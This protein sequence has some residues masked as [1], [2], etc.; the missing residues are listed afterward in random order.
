MTMPMVA[1]ELFP[2]EKTKIITK[3]KGKTL[4]ATLKTADGEPIANKTI[5]F[6]VRGKNFYKKTNS[7]GTATLKFSSYSKMSNYKW[8]FKTTFNGDAKYKAV[9]KQGIIPKPK[10]TRTGKPSCGRCK[11]RGIPYKRFTKTYVNYCPNCYC[12][13]VLGNK[14]KR[15]AV[16][17]GEI[18]CFNCDSDFC[19]YDGKEK[20]P[21][22][23]FLRKA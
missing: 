6:N 7:K 17:E 5:K 19:I 16:A 12:Y 13:G 15:G 11:Q 10:I 20:M 23:V 18:T 2:A 22:R 14:H 3:A 21:R 8:K 4:Y 9:S 1:G